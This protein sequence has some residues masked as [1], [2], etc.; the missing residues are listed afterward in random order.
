MSKPILEVKNLKKYFS[1]NKNMFGKSTGLV[2]AVNDISFEVYDTEI[3]GLVGESGCG[4]STTG[5]CIVRLIDPDSG[6]ISYQSKNNETVNLASEK[7]SK[8]KPYRSEIQMIFQDPY[9]SLNPRMTVQKIISE[10]M[11]IFNNYSKSD[12]R[13]RVASLM[14]RVGLRPEYMERYPHAFSGGQR[15]R[16]GIARALSLNPRLIVCDEALSS[17]DVSVQAQILGLLEDLRDE[18]SMSYIFIAHDLSVVKHICDRVVVM[19]VGR[20][21]EVAETSE[22]FEK[23]LHPY[24]EALLASVPRIST[25]RKKQGLTLE[26]E[27]PDPSNPPQGCAFHPRCIYAKEECSKRLPE[28]CKVSGANGNK[29]QTSCI[30]YDKLELHGIS[31]VENK[32]EGI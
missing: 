24:T 19:Y 1:V 30:F 16:V 5:N 32:K 20:I 15:Q 13:D 9:S 10:P 26:G 6:E 23:P 27:V 4:K 22:L 18:Y 3:L 17:L 29:R 8:L 21:C 14:E 25:D 31:A 11:S 2:Y 12:L 28:L 7:Q